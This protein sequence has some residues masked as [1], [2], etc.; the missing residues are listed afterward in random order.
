MKL[1]GSSDLWSEPA[2][3]VGVTGFALMGLPCLS[4][5]AKLGRGPAL[6][7]CG[8][9]SVP[10][11]PLGQLDGEPGPLP[12]AGEQTDLPAMGADQLLGDGEA[13]PGAAGPGRAGEGLEQLLS[14]AGRQARPIIR[15]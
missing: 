14:G 4:R 7:N 8:A 13:E 9:M 12:G 6:C 2:G 3:G 1:S 11:A 15:D 10:A 5:I